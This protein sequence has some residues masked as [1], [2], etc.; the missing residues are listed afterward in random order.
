MPPTGF[1]STNSAG[2]RPQTYALDRAATRTGNSSDTWPQF[3]TYMKTN[4][5]LRYTDWKCFPRFKSGPKLRSLEG[6][7]KKITWKSRQI[8][9]SAYYTGLHEVGKRS[10]FLLCMRAVAAYNRDPKATNLINV[11]LWFFRYLHRYSVIALSNKSLA[12]LCRL[13]CI[14]RYSISLYYAN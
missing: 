10:A 13:L 4:K 1:E 6:K 5:G 3:Q 14:I 2:E 11:L 8:V 7:Q 9:S 12:I